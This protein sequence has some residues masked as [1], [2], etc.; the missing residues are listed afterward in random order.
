MKDKKLAKFLL[1]FILLAGFFLRFYNIPARYGFD[2]DATRDA[3]IAA[4]GAGS[5]QLPLIG[6]PTSVG[7][8]TF[9]PWYYYQLIVFKLFSGFDYSAW[10]SIGFFSFLSIFIFYKIGNLIGNKWLGL[11]MAAFVSLSSSQVILATTLSNPSSVFF[12]SALSLWAFFKIIQAKVSPWWIFL[13]GLSLGIGVTNHYQMIGYFILPV[14]AFFFT[15]NKKLQYTLILVLGLCVAVLPLFL[16]DVQNNWHTVRGVFYYLLHGTSNPI[17]VP[18]S[19]SIYI[20]DFWPSFWSYTLG[21]PNG[22][23]IAIIVCFIVLCVC[24]QIKRKMSLQVSLLLIAFIINFIYF[25]YYKGERVIYY[26]YYLQP[27]VFICSSYLL[28]SIC[29]FRH[30]MYIGFLIL[31]F[32]CI[33]M[34]SGSLKQLSSNRENLL[35]N[36]LINQLIIEYPRKKFSLY[37]CGTNQRSR[38]YGLALLLDNKQKLSKNGIKIGVVDS[39]CQIEQVSKNK[40]IIIIVLTGSNSQLRT[41]GWIDVS[42]ENVYNAIIRPFGQKNP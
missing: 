5:M 3:L 35:Y 42:P 7:S 31:I 26:L 41:Q 15:K 20:K 32:L 29:K 27:F 33:I 22:I 24:L 25:R 21:V 40:N 19:W 23:G 1:L 9:G 17:Y 10:I 36:N 28:W 30:R 6:P 2:Y 13:F 4:Y 14:I 18:N 37:N 39:S 12:Y 8:F 11:V 38:A 34:T 16:F